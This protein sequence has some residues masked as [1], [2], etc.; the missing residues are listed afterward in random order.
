M[1]AQYRT[2]TRYTLLEL[3]RNR[4]AAGLL[5]LFV[6]LWYYLLGVLIASGPVDFKFSATGAFLRVDSHN[7][8]LLTAGFNTITLILAFLMFASTHASGPFDRRLVLCGYRQSTLMLAKLSALAVAAAAVS[9][10]AVAVL[11]VAWRP[12]GLSLI[13]LSFFLAAL[14]Y[15]ALGL[16]LGV[17]VRSELAGFFLII[18]VSLLDTFFQ[19]PVDNPAANKDFLKT[20]PSYGPMQLGVAGGFG[21][22]FPTRELLLALAWFAGCAVVGLA[23]F[24]LRTRAWGDRGSVSA[25][26]VA[27]PAAA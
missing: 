16:L 18:M 13:W 3:A 21:H 25:A 26:R 5:I 1:L 24:W 27:T 10:Y 22:G 23:I 12:A 7:L 8:T 17:L 11:A 4:L 19:N 6:P 20:F 15:G 9:L 2:A 14:I